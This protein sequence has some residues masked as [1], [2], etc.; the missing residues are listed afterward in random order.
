VLRGQGQ[1]QDMSLKIYDDTID[2]CRS[3]A[4]IARSIERRD[5]DLARQLRRAASSVALNTAEGAY[6]TKGN[7]R[8]RLSTAL[9]SAA[10]VRACLDVAE[11]F[12]VIAPVDADL[13][14]KLGKII[15]TLWRL[16]R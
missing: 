1:E 9:G 14:A 6:T 8:L 12:E 2:L 16:T 10:E 15:A 3:V 4:P 5:G 13:R 7:E 11:A